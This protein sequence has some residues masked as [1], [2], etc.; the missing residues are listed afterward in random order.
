MDIG[1]ATDHGQLGLA[2]SALGRI[3]AHLRKLAD[4]D[5]EPLM[6]SWEKIL[7]ADNRR[8][9]MLGL[10]GEGKPM[11]PVAYRPKPV[12]SVDMT[13]LP[14]NNL[15]SSHYR[16]LDGKPLIPRGLGSRAITNFRTAHAKLSDGSWAVVGAWEGIFDVK[17]R[18]FMGHH[19][20]G[21][22]HLPKRDLRGVR[23]QAVAEAQ[24]A[25]QR[26]LEGFFSTFP[27]AGPPPAF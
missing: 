23:P 15:T 12:K 4:L 1:I 16:V 17:G 6:D 20:E 13:I 9:L 5:Y 24:D 2:G 21:R 22:G 19:F 8:G 7:Q 27:E 11:T 3:E 18:T 10:D 25:L 14:H 26:F